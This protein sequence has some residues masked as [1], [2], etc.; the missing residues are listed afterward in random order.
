MTESKK[1]KCTE[2]YYCK[3][4]GR[5]N[6]GFGHKNYGRGYFY[7]T[8]PEVKHLKDNYGHPRTGLIGCGTAEKTSQLQTKTRPRWCPIR[9]DVRIDELLKDGD[10][11]A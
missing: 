7:C 6:A 11:D 5:A 10:T 9:Q 1:T 3:M 4:K 8:H 2:C